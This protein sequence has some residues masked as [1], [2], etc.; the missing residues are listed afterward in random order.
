MSFNKPKSTQEKVSQGINLK[1]FLGRSP[2]DVEKER[3][4]ELAIERII[5]RSQEGKD[6]NGKEFNPYT[7][8]YANAKGVS[9]ND[10]DM[11]LFGDMLLAI[12]GDTSR[13]DVVELAIEGDEA[14]KAF[15]HMTGYKGHPTIKNRS[16]NKREFFGLSEDEAEAIANSIDTQPV[17]ESSTTT[18]GELID[19]LID[20]ITLDG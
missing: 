17:G 9:V 18:E 5:E 11:T 15:A 1:D 14:V 8:A 4:V 20:R 19:L 12:D 13:Q 7:E 6:R 16:K 10:V 3:F 2:T